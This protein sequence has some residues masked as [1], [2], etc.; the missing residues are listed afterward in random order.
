MRKVVHFNQLKKCNLDEVNDESQ[1]GVNQ[2]NSGNEN[3]NVEGPGRVSQNNSSQTSSEL[4]NQDQNRENAREISDAEEKEQLQ[5]EIHSPIQP[6]GAHRPRMESSQS[7]TRRMRAHRPHVAE[8]RNRDD[9]NHQAEF[10][11]HDG[12]VGQLCEEDEVEGIRNQANVSADEG[13]RAQ[14][15]RLRPTDRVEEESNMVRAHRPHASWS[16]EDDIEDEVDDF[17]EAEQMPENA[18][19]EDDETIQNGLAGE[20]QRPPEYFEGQEMAELGAHRPQT[21]DMPRRL[22]SSVKRLGYLRD[23]LRKLMTCDLSMI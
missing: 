10:N 15:P 20:A 9:A 4:G 23:Y 12:S 16:Q 13:V 7:N 22:S 2:N 21:G 18:V 3:V 1:N 8:R 17:G 14:R 11:M 6:A 19:L 5:T